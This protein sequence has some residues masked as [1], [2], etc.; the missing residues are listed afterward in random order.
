MELFTI[1]T[2]QEEAGSHLVRFLGGERAKLQ[3]H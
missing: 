2:T 3:Q 1:G